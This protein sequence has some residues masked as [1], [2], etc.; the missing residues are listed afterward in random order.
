MAY[1][2]RP[3]ERLQRVEISLTYEQLQKIDPYVTSDRSALIRGIVQEWINQQEVKIRTLESGDS[4]SH[5]GVEYAVESDFELTFSAYA[6]PLKEELL[7]CYH[8]GRNVS[9]IMPAFARFLR[10]HVQKQA[11]DEQMKAFLEEKMYEVGNT[12]DIEST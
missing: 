4:Y 10:D 7:A 6:K 11:H 1:R 8:N 3:D 12:N 2:K 9:Y 5:I